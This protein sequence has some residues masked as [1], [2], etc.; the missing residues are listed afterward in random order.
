MEDDRLSEVLAGIPRVE[1]P[2]NFEQR[3]MNRIKAGEEPVRGE[4]A[5]WPWMKLALPVLALLFVGA[6]LYLSGMFSTNIS[7]LP[8]TAEV[9]VNDPPPLLPDIPVI[10]ADRADDANVVTTAA[11]SGQPSA[12][13]R[14]VERAKQ[15][16]AVRP[17]QN[18]RRRNVPDNVGG[19]SVD[20]AITAAPDVR[21]SNTN[22]NT[23]ANANAN[24]FTPLE[25]TPEFERQASVSVKDIFEL[26]GLKGAYDG[27]GWHVRSVD[28]VGAGKRSG[29][30]DGDVIIA[31]DDTLLNER[32]ELKGNVIFKTIRV[33]RDG[34]EVTLSVNP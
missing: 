25:G 28:P 7:D 16:T 10:E 13:E 19:G 23:N 8:L 22:A 15:N 34:K 26:M 3:V 30:Q 20:R 12:F 4:A 21:A 17:P 32:M 27:R 18:T 31:V 33:L 29:I 2:A 1:A 11:D 6:F 24:F 14:P 9:E 5:M